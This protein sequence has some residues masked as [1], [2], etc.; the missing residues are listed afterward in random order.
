MP[1]IVD[2]QSAAARQLLFAS[3]PSVARFA[4][5]AKPHSVY[6]FSAPLVTQ[7]RDLKPSVNTWPI[8]G[9]YLIATRYCVLPRRRGSTAH[10]NTAKTPTQHKKPVKRSH[11]ASSQHHAAIGQ[12]STYTALFEACRSALLPIDHNAVRAQHSR[13]AV[14]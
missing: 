5:V 14:A 8:L 1:I 13:S 9:Q 11:S 6:I 10:A 2:Q 4:A 3:M 12:S 7:N